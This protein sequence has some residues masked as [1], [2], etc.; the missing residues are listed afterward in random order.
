MNIL[1][2]FLIIPLR[3]ANADSSGR[4]DSVAPIAGI[5]KNGSANIS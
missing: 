5:A 2:S 1:E 4:K 3:P